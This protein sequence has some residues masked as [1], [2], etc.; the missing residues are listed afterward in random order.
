[1]LIAF[2][3]AVPPV[4]SWLARTDRLKFGP[5]ADGW[6]L[7]LLFTSVALAALGVVLSAAWISYAT[8]WVLHRIARRPATLLAARRLIADPWANSRTFAAL[9]TCLVV[10]GGTAWVRAS[11]QLLVAMRTEHER[12]AGRDPS[13]ND[14]YLRTIDLVN[15]AVVVALVI[16]AAGLLIALAEGIVARRRAYAALV[17]TGVPRAVLG[18]SIAWHALAP[19][20]PAIVLALGIGTLM[21]RTYFGGSVREQLTDNGSPVERMIAVPF[22]ALASFGGAGLLGVLATVGVGLIL[23]R[24]STDLEELRVG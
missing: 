14:F 23:L 17:A 22:G 15:L 24:S 8:G 3:L 18:R 5:I 13:S 2:G 12:G 20:V 9:L 1:V 6:L 10:A 21:G 4:L 16:A 7:V 19:A 11:F